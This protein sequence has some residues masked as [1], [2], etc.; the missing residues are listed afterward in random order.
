MSH[1]QPEDDELY[2]ME[3]IAWDVG[4]IFG[5]TTDQGLARARRA[6][7]RAALSI[8]GSKKRR[9]SWMKT[10]DSFN[11][12]S[13]TR[14]YSLRDDVKT[15]HQMWMEGT[16]RQRIDRIPTSD[17]VERVPNPDTATGTPRLF[18]EEGVDSSGARIVSLYPVPS[19]V[20][21]VLYRFT[22]RITMPRDPSA[23]MRVTWG[24]PGELLE[25]LTNKAAALAVQGVNSDKY[26]ELNTLAE[27]QID[28]EYASDQE[29][30]PTTYRAPMIE[31]R[32][33]ISSGPMLPA[34]FGRD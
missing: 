13:G 14:E 20:I 8:T 2:R 27:M 3:N 22:R 4:L 16:N 25:G 26:I 23:D 7:Y 24:M 15:I 32:D 31:G 21:E 11:T 29:S 5:L 30:T 19:S 33:A 1:N 9:W 17:F 6:L 10:K 28:D 18:D 34:T 12:I